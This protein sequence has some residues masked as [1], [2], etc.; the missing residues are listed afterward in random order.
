[1]K[2]PCIFFSNYTYIYIIF[3]FFNSNKNIYFKS[4]LF[5]IMVAQEYNTE[6]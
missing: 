6:F 3:P 2:A 1:M 4:C 5:A